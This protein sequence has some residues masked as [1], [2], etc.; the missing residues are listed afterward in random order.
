MWAAWNIFHIYETKH[1]W[2][3]P[4]PWISFR[5]KKHMEKMEERPTKWWQMKQGRQRQ[6]LW[7]C[8]DTGPSSCTDSET[9][10]TFY[11]SPGR[12]HLQRFSHLTSESLCRRRRSAGPASRAC[13]SQSHGGSPACSTSITWWQSRSSVPWP[14]AAPRTGL[15]LPGSSLWSFP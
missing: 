8:W 1:Y 14:S 9:C 3:D 4:I 5:L 10:Q 13:F 11:W 7:D 12:R 2:R 15:Q 6:E